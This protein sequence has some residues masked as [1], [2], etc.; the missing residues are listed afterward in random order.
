[1]STMKDGLLHHKRH[2]SW[3]KSHKPPNPW[4]RIGVI[5]IIV[6]AIAIGVGIIL[7]YNVSTRWGILGGVIVVGGTFCISFTFLIIYM[8]LYGDGLD[9]RSMPPLVERGGFLL[10]ISANRVCRFFLTCFYNPCDCN[11][12]NMIMAGE[13]DKTAQEIA[14]INDGNGPEPLGVCWLGDSEFT[15]WHNLREDMIS[16]H[17]NNFNAGFGG[18]RIIDMHRHVD[19]LCLKWD[20]EIVIVH[21]GGN[22]FDFSGEDVSPEDTSEALMQLFHKIIAH[23]SV[24]RIGYFLS[25]RR[26]IYKDKK[27]EYFIKKQQLTIDEIKASD[28]SDKIEIFDLRD[29]MHPVEDFLMDRVHLNDEGHAAK[30]KV[31]LPLMLKV[32][33]FDEEL[34]TTT[35]ESEGSVTSKRDSLEIGNGEECVE[36]LI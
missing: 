17:P 30:A 15:F 35:N 11:I 36:P 21:G 8:F 19:K 13:A 24:K 32:W 23:P 9:T 31:L 20:P 3:K 2:E 14:K 28:L 18:S 22:D 10:N 27:W 26:P 29:M 34:G 1:M 12:V 7:A 5:G 33:P 25:S 6:V 4:Y 16:F